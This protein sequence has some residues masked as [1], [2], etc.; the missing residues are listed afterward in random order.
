MFRSAGFHYDREAVSRET[1]LRMNGKGK[2]QQQFKD[3]C[4]IRMIIKNYTRT[5]LIPQRTQMP[6]PAE[7]HETFD[8]MSCQNTLVQ[9][10][11]AFMEL[12]SDIR[13]RFGHDPAE[14][15]R[16]ATDEKN[17]D[18]LVKMG[19]ANVIP[20]VVEKVQKVEIVNPPV[21]ADSSPTKP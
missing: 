2:T 20:A 9:A 14:F 7:F 8:Y 19:L 1:G 13:K 21:N 6:L 18:D 11:R 15:Y 5:G 3:Q 10:K 17:V 4:D 16:F 12:P